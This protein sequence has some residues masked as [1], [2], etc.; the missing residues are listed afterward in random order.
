M[1]EDHIKDIQGSLNSTSSA[2]L[3]TFGSMSLTGDTMGAQPLTLD[4]MTDV[5]VHENITDSDDNEGLA[6]LVAQ[7]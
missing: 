2:A 3:E 5:M 4:L 7:Q 6:K 1:S